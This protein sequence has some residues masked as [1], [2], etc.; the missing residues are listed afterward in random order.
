MP[1][2]RGD[3]VSEVPHRASRRWNDSAVSHRVNQ[4][5]L[6]LLQ[7]QLQCGVRILGTKFNAEMPRAELD[8][9][10]DQRVMLLHHTPLL[11]A[12]LQALELSFVTVVNSALHPDVPPPARTLEYSPDGVLR[13]RKSELLPQIGLQVRQR[14]HVLRRTHKALGDHRHKV[15]EVV[16]VLPIVADLE[17]RQAANRRSY[18]YP[19]PFG[20]FM[21]ESRS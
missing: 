20:S 12:E 21:H 13:Q 4:L 5:K 19:F 8:E 1:H 3:E 2:K 6:V 17:Q 15:I 9:L 16:L 18:I 10:A 11:A 14:N 7:V